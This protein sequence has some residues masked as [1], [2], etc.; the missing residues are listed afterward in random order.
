MKKIYI[1]LSFLF[2]LNINLFSQDDFF[3]STSKIG[4]YGEVHYN[5]EKPENGKSKNV[6]DFH[7]FVLFYSHAWNEKWSLKAEVELEHN[8]V[9]ADD[10]ELELEQ[11]Y[12][13]YHY[14]NWLGFK[15]GV[16]LV[17]SG[18]INEF[19]EPPLFLSVERPD[20]HNKII[21]TTWFGNGISVY[22]NYSGF[23]Y[24][25]NIMEGLL[26][27][28]FSASSGIRNGRQKGFKSNADNLLYNFS[29]D[30]TKISGLKLGASLVYNNS[31]GEIENNAVTLLEGHFSYQKNGLVLLGEFANINYSNGEIKKSN[32][33]Y[34]DLGYD[35]GRLFE[36][37]TQVI[38][39]GRFTNY[40]T[41]AEVES[42]SL[43]DN[44]FKTSKW[45]FGLA[46]KPI[47]EVVIKVDYS[48]RTFGGNDEKT[49]LINAGVGYMF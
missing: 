20:Y 46:V 5:Y 25:L 40:N 36:I 11:A 16:I 8:L 21:P 19:H 22:G 7:R 31:T 32:G 42:V 30:Y 9:A 6:L 2:L 27:D 13:N 1:I 47:D 37:P 38:P 41:A 4:G 33:F 23:N 29:L 24:S 35:I 15:A 48:Q 49:D 26:A 17:S 39:F 43:N 45:M 10:G 44:D 28:K 34:F 3:I 18:L 12:V 14:A